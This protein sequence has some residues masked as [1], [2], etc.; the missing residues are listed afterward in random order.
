MSGA[1][2]IDYGGSNLDTLTVSRVAST[3]VLGQYSRAYYLIFQPLTNYVA[4][5]LTSVLFSALSLIQQDLDRLRRAYGSVL[6]LGSLMLF[7]ICAGLAVAAPELVE[8][9][10]GPQWNLAVGLV[11]WFALAGACHVLSQLTQLLADARAEL[12][13]SLLVQIAYLVTLA[14]LLAIAVP[15]RSN[16]VWVF[17]AAVAAA[18]LLRYLGY[19]ALARRVLHMSAGQVWRAHGPALLASGGVAV[20]VAATR[21]AL[22]GQFRSLVVLGAEAAAGALA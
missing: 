10:L 7:P 4:Q 20:A 18:E 1:A 8:V 12:N 19:L 17:A 11:P 21:W 13:R 22:A 15:F 16:G 14:V 3:A 5:A 6:S 2:L 9:V